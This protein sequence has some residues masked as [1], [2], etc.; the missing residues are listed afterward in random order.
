M[1]ISRE[2]VG[3]SLPAQNNHKQLIVAP[4]KQKPILDSFRK[5]LVA[6]LGLAVVTGAQ[7]ANYTWVGT[8][9][10]TWSN[11]AN[12]SGGSYPAVGSS[13]ANRLNV[14]NH[15]ANT[16]VYNFPGQTTTF[17]NSVAGARGLVIGS[18]GTGGNGSGAMIIQAGTISTLGSAASDVIGNN[19]GN[20]GSLTVNGGTYIGTAAGTGLGIGGGPTSILTITNGGTATVAN[21]NYNTTTGT[22][23]LD[24][25]TLSATNINRTSGTATFN[26]NS[27]TLKPRANRTDFLAG[28][29]RANVRNGGAV[30]DTDGRAI[31]IGQ[32]LLHSN[33]GGDNTTDGGLTKN[34]NGTLTLT[35]TS[36]YNGGTVINAG[37]LALGNATDTLLNTNAINVNS[38]TLDIGANAD[39]VGAVTLTSGSITGSGGTLT[40]SSYDVQSGTVSAILGGNAVVLTK[41]TGGT[42]TLSGANTYTGDTVIS[43]GTLALGLSGSLATNSSLTI[44]S[45]ATLDVSAQTSYTLGSAAS[46][47]ASGSATTP[48]VIQ[49][50]TTVDLGTRPVILNYTADSFAG[51][52]DSPAL[53]L[54]Q[55]ALTINSGITVV[56]NGGTP[57]GNGTYVLISQASGTITGSP[58]RSGLVGGSGIEAGKV[59]NVQ[60]N[61]G[62]VELVIQD[63]IATT[64][65]L[66]RTNSTPASSTYGDVLAFGVTVTPS[67]ATGT[68][69]L[70]NNGVGG[71]LIGTGT[72]SGGVCTI[73]PAETA[74]DVGSHTNLVAL[75]LGDT[76]YGVSTSAAL[77]PGQSVSAKALTVS[78]AV[79]QNKFYD[80]TTSAIITGGSL[81]I[82]SGPGQVEIGDTVTLSQSGTFA[83]VGPGTGISVAC[84][85]TL[86]GAD[87]SNYTVTEPTALSAEI[88]ASP[89]WTGAAADTL[90]DTGGNW[91]GGIAAVGANVTANFNSLNITNDQTV[92][93]N[94]ARTIGS[95]TFGDTD[96]SSAA[97]WTL[98]NNGTAANTLRLEGSA[99]TVT[100][101][102]LGGSASVTVSAVVAGTNGLT[103]AGTGKLVLSGANTFSGPATISNGTVVAQNNAA[104]GSPSAGTTVAGGSTLELGG[105][106]G[107]DALNLGSEVVTVSGTGVGG[108]G[109]LVHTGPNTQISALQQVV[110]AGNT[111]VGGSQRWDMRGGTSVLDMGLNTLTKTGSNYIALV[112]TTITNAGNIDIQQGTLGIQTSANIGGSASNTVTVQAGAA[113]E[114]YLTATPQNWSL[115]MQG[116]STFWAESSSTASE[117]VWAGPVTLNGA[118]TFRADGVLTISNIISGAS[119]SITKIGAFTATLAGNNT[120]GGTTTVSNGTLIVNGDQS[121]A[122]GAVTVLSGATLGGAGSVGGAVTI[123]SGARLSPGS[124]GIGILTN[125]SLTLSAGSTANFEITDSSTLDQ[126][127]V[128]TSGGLTLGGV[129]FNVYQPGTTTAFTGNGTYTLFQVLRH[130][131]WQSRQPGDPQFPAGQDLCLLHRW[132]QCP[133]DHRRWADAHLLGLGRG[134]QLGH[135]GELVAGYGAQRPVCRGQLW[136]SR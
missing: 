123:S 107:T 72:L 17:A 75:Y 31:T 52:T 59:A 22:V 104:L 19:S 133:V 71:T 130:P 67:A 14:S 64:T 118:V 20:T 106:L 62:N 126:V 89:V 9:N 36:A 29:T 45:G 129:G 28:L 44:A 135:G 131:E 94:S 99:P 125:T 122:T 102:A 132:R 54:S 30:I 76:T 42:V 82:G 5:I 43:A 61:G 108:N 83:S 41:T 4:M 33:I 91:A 10:T 77:S 111:T 23:N 35:N 48:A 37:T 78:G 74:L 8:A 21:L 40:G 26:F 56:N 116:G 15:L 68:V 110:L 12:W 121:A 2:Y 27:G 81:T 119:G 13:G 53:S 46:L 109:A 88:Y 63:A 6:V 79:A 92:N 103:K 24:G 105:N 34:G 47:T 86:G 97:G 39:T 85:S 120:Y 84:N 58:F 127:V 90:W 100:V 124:G 128:T 38:G 113:I 18:G 70:W 32:A 136:R 96:T 112:G 134:R 66:Y 101:N 93:L 73:T 49:G 7:A 65:D 51:D 16:L 95:L 11:A 114:N 50:G 3:T 57:L 69:E 87:A 115:V 55:G 98:A 117:N 80:G 25:G 1:P 60:V